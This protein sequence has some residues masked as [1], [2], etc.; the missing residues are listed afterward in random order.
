MQAEARVQRSMSI[1]TSLPSRNY[2]ITR[3]ASLP[4]RT[5]AGSG[6]KLPPLP[7]GSV[8][9]ITGS[10]GQIIVPRFSVSDSEFKQQVSSTS[11]SPTQGV[12]M[13]ILVLS[14][15]AG[16]VCCVIE[17]VCKDEFLYL[18]EIPSKSS[19]SAIVSILLPI[20]CISMCLFSFV[21]HFLHLIGQCDYIGLSP[22]R[23][24]VVEIVIT[25]MLSLNL[26]T[27][28]ALSGFY[29]IA[30]RK[31]TTQFGL[32]FSVV[33]VACGAIRVVNLIAELK[34]LVSGKLT[35]NSEKVKPEEVKMN[36]IKG[37]KTS[38]SSNHSGKLIKTGDQNSNVV[39]KSSIESNDYEDDDVFVDVSI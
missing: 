32:I 34:K 39:K 18:N 15:L 20:A 22:L 3:H 9:S 17:P 31:L 11:S 25:L 16:F 4:T 2:A 27:M 33:S 6:P 35:A 19:C 24:L 28:V 36:A 37:Q 30:L 8:S 38:S 23:K 10:G 5:S 7:R 13:V 29:T 12:L 1:K 14:S 26:L 21:T